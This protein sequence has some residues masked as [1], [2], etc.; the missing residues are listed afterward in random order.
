MRLEELLDLIHAFSGGDV[1]A[2]QFYQR[3]S[4]GLDCRNIARQVLKK[5]DELRI[6]QW[7]EQGED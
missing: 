1:S 6:K 4:L 3:R 7:H 5:L 2:H